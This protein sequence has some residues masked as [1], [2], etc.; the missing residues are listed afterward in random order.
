MA[1][2]EKRFTTTRS[3]VEA[4]AAD[5]RPPCA[6]RPIASKPAHSPIKAIP[7][8]KA[9]VVEE[10]PFPSCRGAV[11]VGADNVRVGGQWTHPK[12][13]YV[14][15]RLRSRTRFQDQVDDPRR[16]LHDYRL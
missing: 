9:V 14:G 1:R 5:G 2:P 12:A 13:V 6:E 4:R 16:S 8:R 11:I 7:G 15:G 10:P 3:V